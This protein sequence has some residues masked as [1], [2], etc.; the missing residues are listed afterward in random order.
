MGDAF[1]VPFILSWNKLNMKENRMVDV[2]V[3]KKFN[4]TQIVYIIYLGN[5]L[6]KL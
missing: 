1:S 4:L 3:K 2:T 5:V 6:V